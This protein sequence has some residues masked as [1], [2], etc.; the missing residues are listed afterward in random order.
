MS[1]GIDSA[2]TAKLMKDKIELEAVHFSQEPFTDS[3]PEKKSQQ[4]CDKL[5]I[6]LHV[7]NISKE[8]KDISEKCQ[9]KYYF[10]LSKRLM[11]K[12][13]EELAIKLKADVLVNGENLGQVS[14]QT[15]H[16]LRTID[17]ATKMTILR[18][19]LT[20]DK[21]ETIKKARKFN[22][23]DIATG[24]EM[25]D[26]LGPKYPATKSSIKLIEAEECKLQT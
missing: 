21:E 16:N 1:G 24:P 3:S 19:L 15:L 9:H 12:K 14:S 22:L 20:Y 23:Y 2:V 7:I 13:A 25:C 6:K 17:A 11:H 18:P 4:I 5:N 10:V 26:A 8:L